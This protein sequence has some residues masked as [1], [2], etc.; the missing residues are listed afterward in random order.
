MNPV[1]VA[2]CAIYGAFAFGV[3]CGIRVGRDGTEY[4][5]PLEVTE[6]PS[7]VGDV[8]R[9]RAPYGVSPIGRP[10]DDERD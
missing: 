9:L 6:P 2:M 10:W 1:I 4:P 5:E 3:L 8:R 7:A